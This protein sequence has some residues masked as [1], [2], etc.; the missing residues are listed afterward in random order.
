MLK[1]IVAL[2]SLFALVTPTVANARHVQTSK[3][4]YET[5]DG[6]SKW[7][8]VDVTYLAGAELNTATN[9]FRYNGFANY[10]VIFWDKDEASVIKISSFMICGMEL[11]ASCM[12]SFGNM[13]GKD[14][15]GRGWEI[16]TSDLC[17]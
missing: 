5:Q 9:S 12:P 17:F 16:C 3:V 2:F 15:Q 11:T 1:R 14:Q 10:A 6:R 13:K 8:S 7:Y 4:R